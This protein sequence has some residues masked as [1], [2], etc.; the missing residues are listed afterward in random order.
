MPRYQMRMRRQL[1]CAKKR[2]VELGPSYISKIIKHIAAG[3]VESR[4][5]I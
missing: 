4:M 5:L 3:S 2:L 1:R